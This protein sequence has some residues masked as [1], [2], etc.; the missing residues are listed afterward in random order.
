MTAP[1]NVV[2]KNPESCTETEAQDFMAMV[3]ASGEV[4]GSG[5]EN[6]VRSAKC[7]IFL[8]R[9]SCLQGVAALKRPLLNY[10]DEITV[11]VYDFATT[12]KVTAS[13]NERLTE[14]PMNLDSWLIVSSPLHAPRL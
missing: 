3:R 10:L 5:L 12:T 13:L 11:G 8:Y 14:Q 9:D 1:I 4:S 6:R 2:T 7:L